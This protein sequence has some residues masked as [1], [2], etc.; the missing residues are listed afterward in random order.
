MTALSNRDRGVKESYL[1]CIFDL[2]LI[3]PKMELK[4]H[5]AG[6]CWREITR[7]R[8]LSPVTPVFLSPRQLGGEKWESG[9]SVAAFIE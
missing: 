4:H 9:R 7:A 2:L 1:V 3:Q 8:F 5:Q 6:L